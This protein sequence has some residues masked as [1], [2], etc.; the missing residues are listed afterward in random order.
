[1]QFYYKNKGEIPQMSSQCRKGEIVF[2]NLWYNCAH[3]KLSPAVGTWF[4]YPNH[5]KN[6]YTPN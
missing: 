5:S 6:A 4:V 3:L 2:Y 1:M